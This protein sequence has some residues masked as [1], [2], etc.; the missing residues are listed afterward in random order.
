MPV[1]GQLVIGPP[2]SGKTTYIKAMRDYYK[3]FKREV[4][5]IN[6]DP[7]NENI[8]SNNINEKS[9]IYEKVFDV[10]IRELINLDDVASELKLG[11][12]A[13]FLYIFDFL[14]KNLEWL[15]NKMKLFDRSKEEQQNINKFENDNDSTS[16]IKQ[17]INSS[18][19]KKK[20]VTCDEINAQYFYLI[21]TPGQTELF[22]LSNSFKNIIKKLT[23]LKTFDL[24]LCC[25]NLIESNNLQD[26]PKYV[27][28][29]FGVLN[30]MIQLEMPQVNI[31][32]KID[33]VKSLSGSKR[34][35]PLS[36]YLNPDGESLASY[37]DELTS[38]QERS[39]I[40]FTKLNKLISE[41]ICD[42]NLV[43]FTFMDVSNRKHL[44]KIS[45]LVDKAIGYYQE[46]NYN[47]QEETYLDQRYQIAE[48]DLK[49]EQDDEDNLDEYD[50]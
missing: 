3:E 40:R 1:F 27:F 17:V 18:E 30:S 21:D 23:E 50:A 31:I 11:P 37:L 25:V 47:N 8:Y 36:F 28:S 43:G 14:E 38:N 20:E 33:L 41:F 12:N 24:R 46:G 34:P 10:D 2:G 6:L 42:Y 26:I 4:L 16:I 15:I 5:V 9:Q 39:D 45:C 49:R 44:N 22:C 19:Y 29:L 35:F 13:S 48:V 32:S 7:A